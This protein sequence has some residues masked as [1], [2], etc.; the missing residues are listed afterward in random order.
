MRIQ[1]VSHITWTQQ[2]T[3]IVSMKKLEVISLKKYVFVE[4]ST[5]NG[6][7]GIYM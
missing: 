6:I 5:M 4:V 3:G 7:C 1:D 2:A